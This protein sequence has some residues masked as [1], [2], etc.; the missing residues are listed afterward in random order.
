MWSG[1]SSGVSEAVCGGQSL[2]F[3]AEAV[4]TLPLDHRVSEGVAHTASDTH[5]SERVAH[6]AS[7]THVSEG[8]AHTAPDTHV[9]QSLPARAQVLNLLASLV[10]KYK[11]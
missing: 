9:G 3:N 4:S 1:F 7:D 8:V 10:Q 5:V 11:Y 6:T 2:C